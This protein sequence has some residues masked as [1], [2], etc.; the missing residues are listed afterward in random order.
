M[1]VCER[2]RAVTWFRDAP[3]NDR[4]FREAVARKLAGPPSLPQQGPPPGGPDR[5]LTGESGLSQGLATVTTYLDRAR[6]RSSTACWICPKEAGK[7]ATVMC[8][9]CAH[10][11]CSEHAPK[12]EKG[13]PWV[14]PACAQ[15]VQSLP[16]W[17]Q[18]SGVGGSCASVPIKMER[19]PLAILLT[20]GTTSSR[21]S[22]VRRAPRNQHERGHPLPPYT[23]LTGV[24]ACAV[25]GRHWSAPWR[26]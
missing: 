16:P 3:A 24:C 10:V 2:E 18:G 8:R 12:K 14:C 5:G 21:H 26:P 9:P 23:Y 25:G 22:K 19:R 11:C 4:G 6:H 1:I 7:P 17:P 13:Q 20:T 15:P